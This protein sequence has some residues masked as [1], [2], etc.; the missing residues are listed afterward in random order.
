MKRSLSLILLSAACVLALAAV[1]TL[2][3]CTAKGGNDPT[4]SITPPDPQPDAVGQSATYTSGNVDMALT[5][6]DGWQW[7]AVQHKEENTEGI[8]FWKTGDKAL[9]FQLL[10]WRDGFGLCGTDLTS[11]EVTLPNG[12][13]VWQHT[14]E[15][16]DSL[17]LNIYF[18]NVPGDYVCAPT[19]TFTQETWKACR[20]ELLSILDTAQLGRGIM[21]EQQ[22]IDAAK[23]QFNGEYDT[24]YGRYDVSGGSWTVYFSRGAMG[25]QSGRFAVA[26]DGTVTAAANT[27][28]ET[29]K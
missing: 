17:W 3:G 9:D 2:S 7:E 12:Q 1:V 25:Q 21:T 28:D 11:E 8:H 4:G 29:E 14:Q 22:A 19:G 24:A 15:S 23:A 10:C 27:G 16:S 13:K 18:E 6:P 5:L 26:A 20:D